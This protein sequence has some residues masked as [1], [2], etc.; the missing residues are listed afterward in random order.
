MG[1]GASSS[2]HL[3]PVVPP[4]ISRQSNSS[5][6]SPTDVELEGERDEDNREDEVG[7]KDTGVSSGSRSL[8]RSK[9]ST[10]GSYPVCADVSVGGAVLDPTR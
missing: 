6:E 8:H 7:D 2:I 5:A 1:S 9:R 3:P 4:H 10:S